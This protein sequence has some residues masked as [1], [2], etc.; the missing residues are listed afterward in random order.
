MIHCFT[1]NLHR[2]IK[3]VEFAEPLGIERD[4]TDVHVRDD[5]T[6]RL[7]MGVDE[8]GADFLKLMPRNDK[9]I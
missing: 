3:A 4:I 1:F 9:K 6:L 8:G 7:E 2:N 5:D